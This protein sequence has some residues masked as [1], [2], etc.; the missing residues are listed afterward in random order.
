MLHDALGPL[1]KSA[2]SLVIGLELAA[3]DGVEL[4]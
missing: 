2:V 4:G 3:D 1:Q